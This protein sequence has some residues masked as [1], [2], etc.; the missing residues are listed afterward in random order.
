MSKYLVFSHG[1]GVKKDDRGLLTDIAENFPKYESVL[2]D[3]NDVD[4]QHNTLTVAPL[5]RQ[6]EILQDE[7]DIVRQSDPDAVTSL[8][9]HSQGCVVAAL[10]NPSDIKQ[11]IFLTP[12]GYVST[13]RIREFFGKRPG[14]VVEDDDTMRVPRADGS[15]TRIPQQFLDDIESVDVTKLYTRFAH[16]T[17]LTIIVADQD[18]VLK[19]IDFGYLA[20]DVRLLNIDGDHNFTGDDRIGLINQLKE[21]L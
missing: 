2:F 16:Q 19:P 10:A 8:V 6:A 3:Y 15:T 1:F 9:C 7:I 18:E 11:A 5:R 17:K 12:P 14:T 20:E 4:E 21:I 13:D